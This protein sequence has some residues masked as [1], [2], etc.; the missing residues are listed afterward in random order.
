MHKNT[1]IHSAYMHVMCNY[2]SS[3]TVLCLCQSTALMHKQLWSW[4]ATVVALQQH[5]ADHSAQP[6]K[7]CE[8]FE[9]C[10]PHQQVHVTSTITV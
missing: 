1:V 7:A 5:L 3:P 6:K 10:W 8:G 9:E 2:I 4:G